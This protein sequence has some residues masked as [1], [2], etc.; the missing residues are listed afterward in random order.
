MS[1][2]S[3]RQTSRLLPRRTFNFSPR[4]GLSYS[5]TDKT[6]VRGGFG[7][8]FGGIEAVGFFPNLG[9]NPPFLFTSNITSGSCSVAGACPTNGIT[10]ENGF[11][12]AIAQGLTNFVSTPDMRMYPGNIQTPYTQAF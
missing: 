7:I 4:F 12:A 9:A 3:I 8:F 5:V 2:S 10:L 6:V 1:L 11:N